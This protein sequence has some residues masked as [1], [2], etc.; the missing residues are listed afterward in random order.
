MT[1]I[2]NW[3]ADAGLNVPVDG[4]PDVPINK[5]TSEEYEK[6]K[7]LKRTP[8]GKEYYCVQVERTFLADDGQKIKDIS[9]IAWRWKDQVEW[10]THLVMPDPE[11]EVRS[12]YIIF[13]TY[14]TPAIS[15]MGTGFDTKN[16]GVP[17]DA[18]KT[19][20]HKLFRE[21]KLSAFRDQVNRERENVYA[22][23]KVYAAIK[24]EIAQIER[25][26]KLKADKEQLEKFYADSVKSAI[27]ALKISK[28]EIPTCNA[29]FESFARDY[30]RLGS[31]GLPNDAHIAGIFCSKCGDGVPAKR[32]V[33]LQQ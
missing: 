18:E 20:M 6:N 15:V 9:T 28:D 10:T 5:K 24:N 8:E 33:R 19:R 22:F 21:N 31:R 14:L 27:K 26:A 12:D 13:S 16:T 3:A 30:P 4:I 7:I 1:Y 23:D 11:P 25:D 2:P 17:T 29:H 32:L